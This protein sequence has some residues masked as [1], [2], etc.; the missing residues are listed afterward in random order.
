MGSLELRWGLII[1]GANLIWLYLSFY[2]GMHSSGLKGIQIMSLVGVL[3][4]VSGYLLAL[5]TL[6]RRFPETDYRDGLRSGALIAGVAAVVAVLAQVGYFTLVNPGFTDEMVA[7]TRAYY[8]EAGLPEQEATQIAEGARTTYGIGFHTF[9]A[10]LGAVMIG[11]VSSA[12][13]MIF[14]RGKEAA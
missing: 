6:T 7:L 8:L 14:L 11:M 1:G 3:L 13:M 10:A 9:Q 5:R 4:S 2:L 12:I